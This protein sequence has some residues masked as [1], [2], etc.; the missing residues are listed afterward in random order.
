MFFVTRILCLAFSNEFIKRNTKSDFDGEKSL[1][2]FNKFKLFIEHIDLSVCNRGFDLEL[3]TI[4][5]L[6][7]KHHKKHHLIVDEV[8]KIASHFFKMTL[9]LDRSFFFKARVTDVSIH[10][11]NLW[12][13]N[14]TLL[15]TFKDGLKWSDFCTRTVGTTV[16]KDKNCDYIHF[17]K[18]FYPKIDI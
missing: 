13:K 3:W 4:L 6:Y 14:V 9:S 11:S 17:W 7:Q 12:R 8:S 18:E 2:S 10:P 5:C 16:Q 1:N 15:S